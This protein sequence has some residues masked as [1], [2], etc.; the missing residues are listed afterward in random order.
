MLALATLFWGMGFSWAKNVGEALNRAASLPV[1]VATGPVAALGVRFTVAALLWIVFVPAS[2]RDWTWRTL[3]RGSLIGASLS[4]ALI[5]QH[6]G[7]GLSDESVIAFLTNLTVIFVPAWVMLAGR[8]WP[9]RGVLLAVPIALL[10]MALLSGVRG[11]SVNAGTGAAWG[12]ACAAA[13]AVEILLLDR[14]TRGQSAARI[15]LL[16]FLTSAVTCFAVAALLPGF[17]D[18]RWRTLT[19]G[20]FLADMVPLIGLTTL[21][22]FAIMTVYQPKV[23]P[24]RAAVIYLLEPLF[25]AGFA[26]WHNGRTMS[27]DALAGAALILSANVIAEWKPRRV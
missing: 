12:V 2:R 26:W 15:T 24:T 17:W 4:L 8:T 11:T 25:A 21:A 1:T 27:A 9:R 10:G 7:L 6:V 23:D 3:W 16:L 5:L 13:F 14:L 19:D 20:P 18:I 22:A